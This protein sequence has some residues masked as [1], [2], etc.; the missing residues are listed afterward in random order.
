VLPALVPVLPSSEVVEG[1]QRGAPVVVVDPIDVRLA[2]VAA[3]VVVSPIRPELAP[4]LILSI[5]LSA[6]GVVLGAM[7][8]STAAA[9]LLRRAPAHGLEHLAGLECGDYADAVMG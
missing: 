4:A 6:L 5:D 3:R 7:E 1:C 9:R 8:A 2:V